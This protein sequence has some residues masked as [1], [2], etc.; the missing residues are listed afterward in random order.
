MEPFLECL[1]EILCVPF[2]G[3][4]ENSN[5][6]KLGKF[7]EAVKAIIMIAIMLMVIGALVG[8]ALLA[9]GE[10]LLFPGA[11][12]AGVCGGLLA[13]YLCIAI[14]LYIKSRK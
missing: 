10:E 13:I 11:I 6:S 12:V 5:L 14:P 8:L 9:G 3:M 1:L 4:M 7:E 2:L